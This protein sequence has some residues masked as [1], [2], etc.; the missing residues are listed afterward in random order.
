MRHRP[1][2][3]IIIAATLVAIAL[4]LPLQIMV[5]Y[6]H[7]FG[8]WP[9]VLDKLTWLNWLTLG[10][11]VATGLLVYRA[12]GL[13]RYAIPA[14]TGVVAL[15]NFFVGYFATDFSFLS[16]S[17]G[18]LSFGALTVPLYF[19]S[20]R[21]FFLH[22]ERRWWRAKVRVTKNIPVFVG[23]THTKI[24][25]ETF[26]ISE[27]GIFVPLSSDMLPLE[28]E[29]SLCLTLGAHRQLLCSARVVRRGP[30]KGSY[31]AGVG[32]Q[33]TGLTW[34]QRRELKDYLARQLEPG[35]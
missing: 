23:G 19:G 8:E 14:V 30:A 33:F 35:L 22:P 12:S 6:G 18:T 13:A 16:A 9:Q 3:L 34:S 26:D 2:T 31:P 27:S 1:F 24:S 25:G 5:L 11:C 32:L 20:S 21:E 28:G 17:L 4:S 15:N 29:V 7:G 10:G